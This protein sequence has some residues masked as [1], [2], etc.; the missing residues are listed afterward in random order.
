MRTTEKLGK[1]VVV[2]LIILNVMNFSGCGKKWYVGS[3]EPQSWE[4]FPKNNKISPQQALQLSEPF[5]DKTFELRTK[6]R[7][8]EIRSDLPKEDSIILQGRYYYVVRENY[9][10]KYIAFYLKHAVK[11]N[12]NTGEVTPPE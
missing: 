12:K 10:A 5:L 3:R 2:I 8:L 1:V 7:S 9:P 4:H 6:N 11:V